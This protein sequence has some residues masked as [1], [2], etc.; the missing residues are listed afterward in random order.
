MKEKIII[1]IVTLLLFITPVTVLAESE[2]RESFLTDTEIGFIPEGYNYYIA[3][4]WGYNDGYY[5]GFFVNEPVITGEYL[6]GS[7]TSYKLQD[8]EKCLYYRFD[9]E[10]KMK[11]YLY[12]NDFSGVKEVYKKDF[13]DFMRVDLNNTNM[14]YSNFDIINGDSIYY[15]SNPY[16]FY[17]TNLKGGYYSS[18]ILDSVLA[19]IKFLVPIILVFIVGYIG[20]KKAF[21]FITSTIRGC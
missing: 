10:D 15:R 20:F 19:A 5:V 6:D 21:N 13:L 2:T 18:D 3:H 11:D 8:I 14:Y 9:S 17:K 7:Y 16:F 12:N 4:K 1:L